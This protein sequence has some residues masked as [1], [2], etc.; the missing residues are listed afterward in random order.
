MGTVT[1]AA[2]IESL[3]GYSTRR[4]RSPDEYLDRVEEGTQHFTGPA[5]H[6]VLQIL[7]QASEISGPPNV[8]AE[9]QAT[10]E[11]DRI[12][13]A[14]GWAIDRADHAQSVSGNAIVVATAN[15]GSY[16]T[17]TWLT[18]GSSLAALEEGTSK[19]DSDP[20][21]RHRLSLS[22]GLFAPGSGHGT[23]ARRI[24]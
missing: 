22:G 17:I 15:A 4:T 6:T 14:V 1:W 2:R 18:H 10:T 23:L 21:F 16:G 20:G 12:A 24:A 3:P 9:V 13:S 19:V 7:H 5:E 8:V 11:V